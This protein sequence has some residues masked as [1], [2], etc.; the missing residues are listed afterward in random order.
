ME[1]KVIVDMDFVMCDSGFLNMI[2]KFLGTNYMESDFTNYYMQ[3]VI[4]DIETFYEY[5][6]HNNMYECCTIYPYA[7][8]VLKELN[9][10]Y[11][12]LIASSCILPGMNINLLKKHICNKIDFLST[13][14]PF[15][16]FNQ[17]A[18]LDDKKALTPYCKIDDKLSN[19]EGAEIK[20]LYTAYNNLNYDKSFLEGENIIRADDW[21][22]IKR[23]LLK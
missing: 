7:Q 20:L 2:N 11:R 22:D 6:T 21:K 4:S 18:F 23:I 17:Y 12:I 1:K 14:F 16:N 9:N 13:N 8:E 15:I 10:K 3:E 19:L 5:L